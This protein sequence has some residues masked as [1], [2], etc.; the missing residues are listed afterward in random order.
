MPLRLQSLELQGYKSFATRNSFEFAEGVTAIVGPNGSGKSNISDALRWVLGEQSYML[1]RGKKTE[2]M[3]FNGS[4]GRPRAGMA[5]VSIVFD[6]HTG[7]LP[8]DFSEVAIGRRAY[9]DGRNDYLINGQHVRL[10]ELNELLAQSGLS[11]RTYTILGQGM[12][13][14]SLALRSEDRRRLFEEAAG[15]SLYRSRREE[16]LRRLEATE[17]NLDR[18]LDILS[19]LEPRLKS[20]ER[21]ARRAQEYR[22]VQEDLRAL[23]REWYGFHWQRVGHELGEARAAAG[24]QESNL[25]E[26]REGFDRSMSKVGALRRRLGE[27]RARLHGWNHQVAEALEQREAISRELAVL[28]ER[29]RLLAQDL[30]EA[31]AEVGRL[32]DESEA[33]SEDV[34]EAQA[35]ATR[36]EGELGEAQAREH[37][38]RRQVSARRDERT[39]AEAQLEAAR[40]QLGELISRK[41]QMTAQVSELSARLESQRIRLGAAATTLVATEAAAVIG[42]EALAS[43]T[44]VRVGAEQAAHQAEGARRA[45]GEHLENL[46]AERRARVEERSAQAAEHARQAAQRQVVAEALQSLEGLADGAR[47]VLEAAGDSRLSGSRGALAT[48]LQV[49]VELETALAAA[50]GEHMDAILLDGD[51]SLEEA[52][53]FLEHDSAGRAALL[54]LDWLAPTA[55]LDPPVDAACLGVA[56]ML[57]S[58]PEEARPAI[59]MLLGQTLIVRDRRSARRLLKESGAQ[60]VVTLLGEVFRADGLVLAGKESRSSVFSRRR[61]EKDLGASLVALEAGLA[62]LDQSLRGLDA[63]M[64]RAREEFARAEESLVQGNRN[65]SEARNA[66][67]GAALKAESSQAE[68]QRQRAG[69]ET[70]QRESSQAHEGRTGL[71]ESLRLMEAEIL[72]RQDTVRR[73]AAELAALDLQEVTDQVTFWST[74]AQ[75]TAQALAE[76]QRRLDE[77]ALTVGRMEIQRQA[78]A[79]KAAELEELLEKLGAAQSSLGMQEAELVHTLSELRGWIGPAEQEVQSA[80]ADES[81]LADEQAEAQRALLVVERQHAQAQLELARKQEAVEALKRRIEDDFGLVQFEYDAAMEGAVPLPLGDLVETLPNMTALAPELGESL[82]QKKAQLRRMGPVNME[83]RQEYEETLERFNTMSAQIEDLREAEADLH[84]VIGELDEL[85]RAGFTRTFEEVANHFKEIFVRLFGGGSARLILTDPDNLNETG[86]DVEARLP[87]KREQGL[88]LLSGG[89]RSLTAIA[90]VFALLRVAPTPLCVLDEVDAMLDEANVG[91]F[92]DLLVELS[93]HTQFIVITHNRS[94][95]QVADVIYGVTMGRDSVSQVISLKLDQ[96]SENML[97]A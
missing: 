61:E 59:D 79:H 64:A 71:T 73:T 76:A 34:A 39:A 49:P 89:E 54:P 20:L 93:K 26:A 87:G 46:E 12:V 37:E 55:P 22:Q 97:E 67:Q 44:E 88:A 62:V 94:T 27:Q 16:A 68:L 51:R 13:D 90:L 80:E 10:R 50:L 14:A 96:V 28:E 31:Q 66:E 35:D 47:A 2:D 70:I 41:A 5:S 53:E 58:A 29:R 1:L 86:I 19:E 43:A 40:E 24:S 69:Q 18:V 72:A 92:R 38:A 9:R 82:A 11:E 63:E 56:S 65:L 48:K 36:L 45:A 17:R 25:Q 7:W 52:V 8:L 3:I 30:T 57:I 60:R 23:L 75:V 84:E 33:G 32:A 15:I 95:V 81:A 4:D 42:A 77:R 6:N 74:R 21:Q 91:R 78:A 83:A 85:T